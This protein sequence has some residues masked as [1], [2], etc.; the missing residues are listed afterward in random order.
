MQ[1]LAKIGREIY[2]SIDNASMEYM[3]FD[4]NHKHYN[5]CICI[6]IQI[7]EGSSRFSTSF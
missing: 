7:D 5:T 1:H 6:V 4:A 2:K 3:Q